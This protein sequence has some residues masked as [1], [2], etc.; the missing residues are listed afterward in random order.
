VTNVATSVSLFG[1]Y[2]RNGIVDAADYVVWRDHF[3]QSL[4]GGASIGV[5][6]PSIVMMPALAVV[7]ALLRP[8]VMRLRDRR[9]SLQLSNLR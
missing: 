8:S 1:D 3:G 6:E 2:D 4:G 9:L 5:P 7:F